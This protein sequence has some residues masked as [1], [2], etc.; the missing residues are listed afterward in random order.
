MQAPIEP[1]RMDKQGNWPDGKKRPHAVKT[2]AGQ[3][4]H[5]TDEEFDKLL[6]AARHKYYANKQGERKMPRPDFKPGDRVF[7]QWEGTLMQQHA[8]IEDVKLDGRIKAIGACVSVGNKVLLTRMGIGEEPPVEQA[9]IVTS[10][11]GV[12]FRARIVI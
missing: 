7:V 3:I 5:L 9:F 11:K 8:L 1:Q 4:V 12:S 2:E 10:A 6:L